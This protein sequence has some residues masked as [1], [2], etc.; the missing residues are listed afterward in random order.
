MTP[1]PHLRHVPGP[2]TVF[3][4]KYVAILL[5]ILGSLLIL[6]FVLSFFEPSTATVEVNTV[7]KTCIER[8]TLEKII[9]GR[10]LKWHCIDMIEQEVHLFYL[11]LHVRDLRLHSYRMCGS[12]F[13][14]W[15]FVTITVA[16]P[17]GRMR[18]FD[19][20]QKNLA[21][22]VCPTNGK[23]VTKCDD[24]SKNG[25]FLRSSCFPLNFLF[26]PLP[27]KL[28]LVPPLDNHGFDPSCKVPGYYDQSL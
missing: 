11:G 5:F 17:Q 13:R 16:V 15:L 21:S 3:H 25:K 26:F 1:L 10:Y 2:R 28:I 14:S 27:P 20:P 24:F 22:P 4:L 9:D 23:C 19:P 12:V 7:C 6:S 18:H 8:D